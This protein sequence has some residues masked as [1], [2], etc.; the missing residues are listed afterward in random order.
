M[1]PVVNEFFGAVTTVSSLLT[2]RDVIVALKDRRPDQVVLLPRSMF[3]GRYGAGSAPPDTT[4]DDVHVT[5]IGA[6]LGTR[7]AIAATLREALEQVKG[8][9]SR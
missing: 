4:L 7:V 1:L 3:T 9:S 2:A 6:R 5:E 8:P